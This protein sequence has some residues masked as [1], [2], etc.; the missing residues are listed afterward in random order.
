MTKH[1][2]SPGTRAVVFGATLAAL[3]TASFFLI[4]ASR[5]GAEPQANSTERFS[6]LSPATDQM[7]AAVPKATVAGLNLVTGSVL[8]GNQDSQGV[9]AVGFASPP[10][11]ET[12]TVA[13][14]G[15]DICAVRGLDAGC[16]SA[17]D[18]AA[19]RLF[20]AR[21]DGCGSYWVFGVAPDGVSQ[22]SVIEQSS[23]QREAVL[24]VSGNV[25]EGTLNGVS[26]EALGL[27]ESGNVVF[28]TQMPLDYYSET[29]EAC[30]Q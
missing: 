2:Q 4:I 16:A 30:S 29:N 5:S 8:P 7:M 22:I 13:E 18:V 1:L 12:M 25:Y 6:V 11:G 26:T 10:S 23:G 3:I 28:R 14:V 9:S 27:D 15:N 17:D 21:P 20:G 24:P 19:G